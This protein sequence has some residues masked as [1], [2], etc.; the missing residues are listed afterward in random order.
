MIAIILGRVGFAG[1]LRYFLWIRHRVR[2][3]QF[4]LVA[5][6]LLFTLAG[7]LL[8]DSNMLLGLL[9]MLGFVG[10]FAV[11]VLYYRMEYATLMI[12]LISLLL[13]EGVSTGT[14]T[15]ITF[16]FI[17]LVL[18]SGI[19]IFQL[20][21]VKSARQ[22]RPSPANIPAVIFIISVIISLIWSTLYV[23]YAVSYRYA[24]NIKPRLMS[25]VAFILSPMAYL[26]Y[27]N[28]V[29]SDRG[30]RFFVTSYLV[31]S[32]VIIFFRLFSTVPPLLNDDGQIP[33]WTVTLATG[34]LLFNRNLK[35]W[36][37][38]S[39]LVIIALWSYN[40]FGL[41]ITWLSGWLPLALSLGALVFFRSW[42]VFLLA[43]A[44]VAV[45]LLLNAA[46]VSETINAENDES[47]HTRTDAWRVVLELTDDHILFGVGPTGY[48]PYLWTYVGDFMATHNNYLDMLS[49]LGI[50]GFLMYV[51]FWLSILWLAWRTYL[52]A[53]R[54]GFY[55][56][57]SAS[58]VATCLVTLLISALGDWIIPFAYTQ[59]ISGID[60]TIWSWMLAGLTVSVH[61]H[62]RG[63]PERQKE[64]SQLMPASTLSTAVEA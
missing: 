18:V 55:Y 46:S 57:L 11:V 64:P 58:L 13:Q 16:T 38:V 40:Q 25:T 8:M 37:Q 29:R 53:P 24:E 36:V 59:G 45:V 20:A 44:M 39:L 52:M 56:G 51:W 35:H 49:Q 22:I 34:Q 31:I 10:L 50:V 4:S 63:L 61:Y 9:P 2:L 42:K 28:L 48:A 3:I 1:R 60:Y 5:L 27:A 23:D 26:L 30:I 33:V 6:T 19:W 12:L 17:T 14:A 7:A 41:G 43:I 32:G 15:K 62:I 54:T 47:G 21:F